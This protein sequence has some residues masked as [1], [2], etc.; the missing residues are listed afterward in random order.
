MLVENDNPNNASSVG[1]TLPRDVSL[2]RSSRLFSKRLATN[3]PL[4]A[5]LPYNCCREARDERVGTNY[6][7]HLTADERG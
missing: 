4:L 5:E 2:L 1:A 3:I 6:P 7:A